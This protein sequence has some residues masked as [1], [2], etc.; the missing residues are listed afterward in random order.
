MKIWRPAM[1][2]EARPPSNKPGGLRIPQNP[3]LGILISYVA[4][5]WKLPHLA[6]IRFDTAKDEHDQENKSE[7]P[8]NQGEDAETSAGNRATWPHGWCHGHSNREEP[9]NAED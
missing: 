1:E 9:Q 4:D 2:S 7:Q 6:L 3:R 8:L 5:D